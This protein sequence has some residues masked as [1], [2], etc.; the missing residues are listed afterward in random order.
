[1]TQYLATEGPWASWGV[2]HSQGSLCVPRASRWRPAAAVWMGAWL[3]GLPGEG[4]GAGGTRAVN[5]S[6]PP[7]QGARSLGS[8]QQA[9]VRELVGQ[10]SGAHTWGVGGEG[11]FGC[12]WESSRQLGIC[13]R[14]SGVGKGTGPWSERDVVRAAG[15]E[16]RSWRLTRS[17]LLGAGPAPSRGPARSRLLVCLHS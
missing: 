13:S 4:Q 6:A 12:R 3:R 11:V 17:C 2:S 8:L 1:M 5:C 14:R 16:A 7:G 10:D 9:Q 15:E